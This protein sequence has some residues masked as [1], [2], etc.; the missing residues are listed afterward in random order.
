MPPPDRPDTAPATLFSDRGW[1]VPDFRIRQCAPRRTA[2]A[3]VIP[4]INEGERIRKQLQEL[5]RIGAGADVVI[6]D[7]GS[8]DGSLADDFIATVA[9]RAVL[10]KLGP[11]RLSAQLRMAYAWCLAEG[12]AGIITMDGNGKDGVEGVAAFRQKLDEGYDYVQGSRYGRGGSARNTPLDRIIGNRLVHA[13]LLSVAGRHWYSDTTNGFRAYSRRYL[14]DIRVAPFRDV[15]SNYELLFYLTVRA[16]QLGYR[17]C[18]VAVSRS[19]PPHGSTIPTKI[20]DW[21]AKLS[22][23]RQTLCAACGAYRPQ[24]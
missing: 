19:Y 18:E 24:R 16:G 5:Q 4:V 17:T 15:F 1:Q 23:L 12:Y 9:V 10:T 3:L 6:A 20:G 7:G 22:I 14:E 2:Y 13:P 21:S 11:G 8:D